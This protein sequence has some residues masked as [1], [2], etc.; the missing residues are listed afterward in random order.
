MIDSEEMTNHSPGGEIRHGVSHLA[1]DVITLM[2]LQS[3]LLQVDL[4]N[5]LRTCV[6]PTIVGAVIAAVAALASLPLFLL[7]MA[8]YLVQLAHLTM[9]SA[10]LVAACV[11]LLIAAAGAIVAFSAAK[12]GRGAFAR[13]RIE[14][15]RNIR[16]LKQVLGRPVETAENFTPAAANWR[17]R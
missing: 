11:G 16:W 10:L 12:R 5:W 14:F 6:T 2:E 3:E 8:Y 17:P 15:A 7:S 13:F 9:A 4:R 1:R